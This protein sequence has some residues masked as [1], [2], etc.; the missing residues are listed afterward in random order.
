MIFFSYKSFISNHLAVFKTVLPYGIIIKKILPKRTFVCTSIELHQKI[1]LTAATECWVRWVRSQLVNSPFISLPG[2]DEG[3]PHK[4]QKTFA[5]G[6]DGRKQERKK[7]ED[8]SW[9]IEMVI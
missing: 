2:K 6:R 8:K 3:Q 9:L 1:M 5:G 4:C 7:K